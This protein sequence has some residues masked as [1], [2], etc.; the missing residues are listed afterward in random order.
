MLQ[1]AIVAIIVGL[2]GWFV[3]RKYLPKTVRRR[4]AGMT[5]RLM[6]RVAMVRLAAW[7][8]RDLP[9]TASCGDGCGTCGSC[10]PAPASPP[11]SASPVEFSISADALKRTIRRH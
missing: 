10:G 5:A 11:T 2:A 4:T 8:E 1:H 9:A 3:A 7:L 6:R